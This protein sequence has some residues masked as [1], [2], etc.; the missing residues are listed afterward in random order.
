LKLAGVVHADTSGFISESKPKIP[1]HFIGC[2]TTMGDDYR[3]NKENN[4]GFALK[5][6]GLEG[7]RRVFLVKSILCRGL[8]PHLSMAQDRISAQ[9]GAI[10]SS[11]ANSPVYSPEFMLQLTSQDEMQK[12]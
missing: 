1:T 8:L 12:M 7:I 9:P 4:T 2:Q 3:Q 6:Q 5:C 10:S 11:S